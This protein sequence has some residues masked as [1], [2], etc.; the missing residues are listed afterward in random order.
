MVELIKKKEAGGGKSK[1]TNTPKN[2]LENMRN[3]PKI[4]NK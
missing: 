1:Q 3:D 2:D 4:F